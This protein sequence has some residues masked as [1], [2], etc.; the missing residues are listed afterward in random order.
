MPRLSSKKGI[1][2]FVGCVAHGL[3]EGVFEE[4]ESSRL[5]YAARVASGASSVCSGTQ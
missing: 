3:L 1:R 4:S 2:A 5:L